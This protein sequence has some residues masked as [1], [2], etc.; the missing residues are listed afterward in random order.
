VASGCSVVQSAAREGDG[1]SSLD[2]GGPSGFGSSSPRTAPL[3]VSPPSSSPSSRSG[4]ANEIVRR[5][6]SGGVRARETRG[7]LLIGAVVQAGG[8]A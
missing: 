4:V 6:L 8:D 1:F 7:A 2:S 5:Q 3:L